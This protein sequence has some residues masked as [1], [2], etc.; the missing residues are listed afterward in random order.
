VVDNMLAGD[1]KHHP[2]V[3]RG[4]SSPPSGKAAAG[5]AWP[6]CLASERIRQRA[7]LRTAGRRDTL[8]RSEPGV[9]AA[10]NGLADTAARATGRSGIWKP[11][12]RSSRL[13]VGKPLSLTTEDE[14]IVETF[15]ILA[16]IAAAAQA[17]ALIA[18]HL[19][20]TGYNPK[21]NAV[22]DYGIG[23]YRG[24]FWTQTLAGAVACF[25]LAIALGEAKPS[26][27]TLAIVLLVIAGIARL[28]IPV[29]PTDQNGQSVSDRARHDPHDP[30]DRDL[31]RDHR[32]R[33][34]NSAR[35]SNTG[36]R[37]TASRAGSRPSRGS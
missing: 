8:V 20:S 25:A 29:F 23:R 2:A 14:G 19:L 27:P 5:L 16:A 4:V 31:R 7:R 10:S 1:G 32:R 21:L 12:T 36:Q 9:S 37:G 18:L 35:R 15:S 30:G 13:T 26:M 22:S 17:A 3:A 34:K 28:L 6:I 33:F 11:I 24:V